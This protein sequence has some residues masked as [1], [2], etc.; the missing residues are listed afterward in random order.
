MLSQPPLVFEATSLTSFFF[1][2][3]QKRLLKAPSH[4]SLISFKACTVFAPFPVDVFEHSRVDLI[5][6][7]SF[8]LELIGGDGIKLFPSPCHGK[9]GCPRLH[10]QLFFFPARVRDEIKFSFLVSHCPPSFGARGT[11]NATVPC[12]FPLPQLVSLER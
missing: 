5:V 10:L 4:P 12:P 8:P 11:R 7:P 9:R 2:F 1:S 6:P 3:L